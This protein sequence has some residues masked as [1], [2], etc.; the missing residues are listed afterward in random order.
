MKKMRKSLVAQGSL[1]AFFLLVD[2]CGAAFHACPAAPTA[3][4]TAK[5]YSG[6]SM[7]ALL[8]RNCY[9]GI[10]GLAIAVA[11]DGRIVYSEDSALPILKSGSVWRRRNRIEAV[12]AAY[13][14]GAG[15]AC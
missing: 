6:Q 14:G 5:D 7:P 9:R 11:V 8:Q 1:A 10:P 3:I 4:A 15:T 2:I 12:K 13:C